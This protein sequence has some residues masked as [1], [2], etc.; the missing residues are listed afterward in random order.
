MIFVV[1]MA[2]TDGGLAAPVID[3]TNTVEWRDAQNTAGE[4]A[5]F[6]R[7]QTGFEFRSLGHA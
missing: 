7:W 2:T 1:V 6:R 4:S 3:V 5:H